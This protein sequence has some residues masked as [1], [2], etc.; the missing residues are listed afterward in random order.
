MKRSACLVIA[1]LALVL[2]ASAWGTFPG[3]NGKILYYSPDGGRWWLVN[4]DGTGEQDFSLG[5]SID[6]PDWHPTGSKI[7]FAYN[8]A[9]WVANADGTE[10]TILIDGPNY[11]VQPSWSPDG[12][13]LA[14]TDRT[15]DNFISRV[16]IA[17]ADGSNPVPLQTSFN[18]TSS[19]KWHPDGT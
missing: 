16:M 15:A 6:D 9:I 5:Q 14:Y 12:T 4:P 3:V 1:L 8:G 19:P 13:K 17:N 2:P 11:D 18:S 7:A 10:R